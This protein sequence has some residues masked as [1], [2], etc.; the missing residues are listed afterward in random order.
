MKKTVLVVCGT[1]I[2]T[3]TVASEKIK[4]IANEE[5]VQLEIKQAKVTEAKSIIEN[6]KI[7]FIVSTT[8][9]NYEVDVPVI[10]GMAFVSGV[11]KEELMEDIA[12]RLTN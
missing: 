7:D 10:N 9:F 1:G 6:N 8:Q 4:E 5:D 11:G 12:A 3:S 2:A